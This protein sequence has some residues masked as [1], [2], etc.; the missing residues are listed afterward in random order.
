MYEV[1]GNYF[2]STR[3]LGQWNYFLLK[4]YGCDDEGNSLLIKIKKQKD[5]NDDVWLILRLANGKVFTLPGPGI[6]CLSKI[7]SIKINVYLYEVIDRPQTYSNAISDKFESSGLCIETL[8][9]YKS[10]RITFI[11]LLKEISATSNKT[12][13]GVENEAN[14]LRFVKFNFL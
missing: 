1:S 14:Q 11:G 2:S 5:Q 9:H 3:I 7:I 10:L 4:I 13:N 6:W 12:I 8:R